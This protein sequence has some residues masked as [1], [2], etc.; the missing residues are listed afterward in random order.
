[1]AEQGRRTYTS[2]GFIPPE[3]AGIIYL[4]DELPRPIVESQVH[5]V[6]SKH[7]TAWPEGVDGVQIGRAHV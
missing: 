1:M 4:P 2:G 3:E 7:F 6:L 5:G